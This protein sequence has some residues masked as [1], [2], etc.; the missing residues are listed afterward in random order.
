MSTNA[1][2]TETTDAPADAST[3]YTIASGDTFTGTI[4]SF[5]DTDWV[6]IYLDAGVDYTFSLTGADSGDGTLADPYLWL[7]D[8]FEDELAQ[9]DDDGIGLDSELTYTASYSGYYYI[10]ASAY[11]DDYTGTYELSVT[12]SGFPG[13]H[14]NGTNGFDILTGTAGDDTING[15]A[16]NDFLDGLAGDDVIYGGQGNDSLLGRE[17]DDTVYGGNN[18]DNIA[19]DDGNDYAEGGVGDDSIGGGAGNDTIYGENGNDVIGGGTDDDYIDAGADQDAASGGYGADTV[20]GGSGDDTLAGSFGHDLVD[21]GVGDDNMGGG[22]GNDTMLGHDGDDTMG[23][24]DGNDLVDGETGNDFLAGGNGDDTIYGGEGYDT[25][26]AG[27]G[28]DIMYGGYE[29]GDGFSDLFVFNDFNAGEYDE[30]WDFEDGVDLIRVSGVAPA[31]LSF[32]NTEYG[33]EV[34]VGDSG[35]VIYVEG[36][37]SSTLTTDD[38][39][40]V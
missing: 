5:G 26:N 28:D 17:G 40:F 12:A 4:D 36:M 16:A 35:H 6:A 18:H 2:Y 25:I 24:G 9:D 20:I 27:D 22:L 39:M 31:Q 14:I 23:A 10:G 37:D 21:G 33:V 29:G 7:Y 32:T 1:S 8:D 34:E 11:D 30:I 38:F 3:P 19:L 13:Q 15:M